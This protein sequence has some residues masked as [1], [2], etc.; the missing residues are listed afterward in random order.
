[1]T[2]KITACSLYLLLSVGSAH[3][4]GTSVHDTANITVEQPVV[5]SNKWSPSPNAVQDGTRPV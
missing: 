1:M 5:V 4:A 2:A 3:G